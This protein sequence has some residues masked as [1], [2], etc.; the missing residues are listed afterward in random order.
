MFLKLQVFERVAFEDM[1]FKNGSSIETSGSEGKAF[2]NDKGSLEKV[3][4]EIEDYTK[5]KKSIIN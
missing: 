4:F 2:E 1:A 5:L 3:S